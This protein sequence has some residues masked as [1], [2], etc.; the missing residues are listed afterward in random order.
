MLWWAVVVV[1]VLIVDVGAFVCFI[2]KK[3]GFLIVQ[4]IGVGL[5]ILLQLSNVPVPVE[6]V[7]EVEMSSLTLFDVLR[8]SRR[9]CTWCRSL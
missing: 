8:S 9:R 6:D 5:S 1:N 4:T 7:I 3:V 2:S